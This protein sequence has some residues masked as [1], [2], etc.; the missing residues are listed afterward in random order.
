MT[1]EESRVVDLSLRLD[2]GMG[3]NEVIGCCELDIE[4]H[5]W[6]DNGAC[7]VCEPCLGLGAFWVHK[8]TEKLMDRFLLIHYNFSK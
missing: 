8:Q 5:A 4:I 6:Q 2:E 1:C 3:L 7:L